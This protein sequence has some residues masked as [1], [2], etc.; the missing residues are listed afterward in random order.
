MKITKMIMSGALALF[1]A[2]AAFAEHA[3][4]DY[5]ADGNMVLSGK[6]NDN[7]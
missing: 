2:S 3:Y 4:I 7:S 6:Q 1:V 5:D